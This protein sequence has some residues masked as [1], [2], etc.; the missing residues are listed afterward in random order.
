MNYTVYEQK[1]KMASLSQIE[2]L[3][4]SL[5]FK[6]YNPDTELLTNIKHV[7]IKFATQF[8]LSLAD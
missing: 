7:F 6:P 3:P 2:E 5:V 1:T 4:F 8:Y